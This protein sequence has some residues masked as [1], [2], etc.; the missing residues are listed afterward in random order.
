MP[1]S[2]SQDTGIILE[3]PEISSVTM[4]VVPAVA[5]TSCDTL[6]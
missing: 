4:L 2:T 1:S 5:V 3:F 6:L